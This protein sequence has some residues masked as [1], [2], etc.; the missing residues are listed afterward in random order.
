MTDVFFTI[1]KIGKSLY[2]DK[3]SKF[4][5]L[6][7]PVE[8]EE[9]IK[10]IQASLKK[11]YF[12]ARHQCFAY[13]LGFDK[14]IYRSNDDGEPSGSA[15]KPIYNQ[16]LS[17][18]ITNA[19]AV[20][21]RYFGGVKLGVPGLINA[22]KVATKEAIEDAEIIKN[23]IAQKIT[24]SFPY[25]SINNA[26]QITQ[27]ENVKIIDRSFSNDCQMEIA[28]KESAIEIIK[29]KLTNVNLDFEVDDKRIVF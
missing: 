3:N 19:L 7:Y 8:T 20:V 11:E 13:I 10:E 17:A 16:L 12:D 15:G 14:E 22:Y 23:F 24:I 27:N 21:I 26:M 9:E 5:G 4:I 18:N 1:K 29:S 2:K 6:V 28:V 25:S